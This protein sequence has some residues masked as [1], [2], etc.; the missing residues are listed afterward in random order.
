MAF[1]TAIKI[2]GVIGVMIG[3]VL[4][5]AL[6]RT[7]RTMSFYK[8]KS[9]GTKH[10]EKIKWGTYSTLYK[11]IAPFALLVLPVSVMAVGNYHVFEGSQKVESCLGCHVMTPIAHDMMDPES[12]TLAARHFKNKW[13]A[14]KQCFTCHKDYG[15][16]GT[17]KAKIDG[18]RHL[19]KYSLRTYEEPIRFV[20]KF[21]NQ[22]CLACHR[23][24]QRFEGVKS[25][26]T[27]RVRLEENQINCTN[28]HGFPH[29]TALERTP[30]TAR[31]EALLQRSRL[32]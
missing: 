9:D 21:N 27:I 1:V 12:T 18:F 3:I 8:R 14:Q 4:C 30:E 23:G 11:R 25:H 5:L 17:I 10:G 32:Q 13:I 7:D 28:C 29:P 15:L 6:N 26:H 22:N 16:N 2:I 31:G 24:T 20:G 19:V